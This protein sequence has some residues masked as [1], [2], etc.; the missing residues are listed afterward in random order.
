MGRRRETLDRLDK[1]RRAVGPQAVLSRGFTI[2]TATDGTLIRS[3]AN[4]SPGDRITTRFSDGSIDSTVL[5]P[6]PPP[7]PTPRPTNQP[8]PARRPTPRPGD[9]PQ[10][11]LF[12]TP[13]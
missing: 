2:T 12:N 5:S 13:G 11:D 1:L 3:A 9:P 7:Q 8:S 10:M 4:A 6:G